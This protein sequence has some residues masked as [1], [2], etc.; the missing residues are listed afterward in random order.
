FRCAFIDSA[1][2]ICCQVEPQTNQSAPAFRRIRSRNRWRA[3]TVA[4]HRWANLR[5]RRFRH[6]AGVRDAFKLYGIN[7]Q[8]VA[9]GLEVAHEI[10]D[11]PVR[12]LHADGHG[13]AG[14]HWL[15]LRPALF[16][17]AGRRLA[18]SFGPPRAA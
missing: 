4:S 7:D 18:L 5:I 6:R 12:T 3:S 17:G 15:S 16:L 9:G 10:P 1:A 2:K 8:E 14:K 13:D 11:L